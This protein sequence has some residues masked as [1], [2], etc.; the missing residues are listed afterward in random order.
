MGLVLAGGRGSRMQSTLPKSLHKLA[1]KTIIE[2]III[3]LA[4]L[5]LSSIC[6]VLWEHNYSEFLGVLDRISDHLNQPISICLQRD[7]LG[8]AYAAGCSGYL[9]PELPLPE[10]CDGKV[11]RHPHHPLPHSI[12]ICP[13][14]APAICE[15]T[16]NQMIHQ[17]HQKSS[18]L[19]LI[20]CYF[21][22]PF[23]YGRI[24]LNRQ[25]HVERIVE[26]KNASSTEKAIKLCY[27]GIMVAQTHKLF[28]WLGQ[29]QP[30]PV[31][32]EYY[33]TDV[34]AMVKEVKDK[35]GSRDSQR[36]GYESA[37]GS[38][39][40]RA[41]SPHHFLGINSETQKRSLEAIMTSTSDNHTINRQD[42]LKVT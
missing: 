34:I 9:W 30:N 29:V 14:D 19:S 31:T 26:E 36:N 33:L 21:D 37:G 40:Y 11:L 25:E 24:V 35:G 16:I 4:R 22:N 5:P 15:N 1:G 38:Y 2:H 18:P 6:V 27:S 39:L 10:Y 41:N 17:H 32:G 3:H 42:H 20:G 13:G 28:Q 7:P 23:G 12:L 8:T